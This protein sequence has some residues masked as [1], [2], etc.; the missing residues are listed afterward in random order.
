TLALELALLGR[1]KEIKDELFRESIIRLLAP[2]QHEAIQQEILLT[3][4]AM[5]DARYKTRA[6]TALLPFLPSSLQ[7]SIAQEALTALRSIREDQRDERFLV[8]HL[9]ELAPFDE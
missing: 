5:A 4:R 6:L 3:C 8:H 9:K 2:C 1:L 7:G